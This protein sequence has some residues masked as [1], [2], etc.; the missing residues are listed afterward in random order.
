M[1]AEVLRTGVVLT[2]FLAVSDP[3]R[4]R[5]WWVDVLGAVVVQERDPVLLSVW[6]ATVILNP[7]GG[8]TPD[9]PGV[10]VVL[11]DPRRT[12]AFLDVRVPDIAAFHAET[13]ARGARW[14]T[15]PIDRGPE[16][17]GYL[18]DP[19]GHLLEVGQSA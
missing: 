1:P 15:A 16:I 14:L 11:P 4:S 19:D 3:D 5:A 12:P 2:F 8:P 10:D 13:L 6:G 18:Q 17:R 9:K 7:P